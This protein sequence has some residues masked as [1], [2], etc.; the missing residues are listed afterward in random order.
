MIVLENNK[1]QPYHTVSNPVLTTS[2]PPRP[3]LTTSFSSHQPHLVYWTELP[4]HHIPSYTPSP[5]YH[6][7]SSTFQLTTSHLNH[8]LFHQKEDRT[9]KQLSTPYLSTGASINP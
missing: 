9:F 7:I 8:I 2:T 3:R 1:L 6:T 5:P 4:L